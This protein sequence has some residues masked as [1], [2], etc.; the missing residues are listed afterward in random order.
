MQKNAVM[1]K[2]AVK[3]FKN[4]TVLKEIDLDIP[5]GNICGLVGRNGS[6]KT[7]LMKCIC[8]FIPLTSGTVTVFDKII[9]KDTEFSPRTGFI[10]ENPG[11]LPQYSGL[12]NL[13]FLS[14]IKGECTE[15]QL[16]EVMKLVGLIPYDKKK[17]GKYSMGM[18]QRLGIAQAIM[19]SPRLLIFDEPFN[20]LDNRGVSEMRELFLSLKEQGKTILLASH[21]ME[22][23]QILCD[24]VYQMDAG[25]LTKL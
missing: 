9:G 21:N 6:G 25:I 15:E 3:K 8:G 24:E 17:V 12:Q 7:V 13:K 10:I 18:R 20:G 5:E 22:D 4:V 2:R 14:G 1:I 19:D 23:I 11:F 16:V